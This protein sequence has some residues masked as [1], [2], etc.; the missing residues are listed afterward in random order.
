M[1]LALERPA[2]GSLP[3]LHIKALRPGWEEPETRE[4]LFILCLPIMKM[5]TSL[6][7]QHPEQIDLTKDMLCRYFNQH[8]CYETKL[9]LCN[10]HKLIRAQ[11]AQER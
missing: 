5:A 8:I 4:L 1:V 11:K 3:M 6:N 10:N 9:F 2:G 7:R